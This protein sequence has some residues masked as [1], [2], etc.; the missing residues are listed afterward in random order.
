MK[1]FD[2]VKL[3][4]LKERNVYFA[5]NKGLEEAS[6]DIVAFT[7]ADC[8][9]SK[10][11]LKQI[12]ALM[13]NPD[14]LIALGNVSF[15]CKNSFILKIFQDYQNVTAEY[16]VSNFSRRK[17]FGY[18]NNMAV[19]AC[20]FD[21]LGPFAGWPVPGD[22]EF[23]QRCITK[24]V[25]GKIVYIN[26]MKII[27]LEVDTP[28]TWFKKIF[29]Y[30]KHNVLIKRKRMWVREIIQIYG[31]CINRN[32]HAFWKAALSS[33]IMFTLDVCHVVGSL[34]GIVEFILIKRYKR[35]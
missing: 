33:V 11:W 14:I 19:R 16:T 10:D 13:K 23:M 8:V 4:E 15:N 24:E 12:Y 28:A 7:D 9:V 35:R 30:G 26:A 34:C 3:L 27:H 31:E 17:Y 18:T 1:Q 5:R 25:K 6:G 2:R 22:T 29:L 20:L 32:Q 21:T